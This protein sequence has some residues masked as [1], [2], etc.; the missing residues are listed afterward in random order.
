MHLY[1][2]ALDEGETSR[3]MMARARQIGLGHLTAAS[4]VT[5]AEIRALCPNRCQPVGP[6]PPPRPAPSRPPP[7][8]P[9]D[10]RS[11]APRRPST[12]GTRLPATA[13]ARPGARHPRPRAGRHRRR[14]GARRRTTGPR[15]R[16]AT[17]DRSAADA[18]LTE[19]TDAPGPTG[20]VAGTRSETPTNIV[21]V[22]QFCAGWP[23]VAAYHAQYSMMLAA[24][25]DLR[26]VDDWME[27][28]HPPRRH[29]RDRRPPGPRLRR[30]RPGRRGHER[31][32]LDLRR[33]LP[34]R[35]VGPRR[36]AP[37]HRRRR[38]ARR[39]PSRPPSPRPADPSHAVGRGHPI[40]EPVGRVIDP[41]GSAQSSS[42]SVRR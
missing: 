16:R 40:F 20:P 23:A 21:D 7:P 2:L 32:E 19:V 37:G 27:V 3:E 25:P 4:E 24:A 12:D 8:P 22:A 35:H 11:R 15:P 5:D 18:A 9:R 31:P 6:E 1:E 28:H 13:A 33:R 10:R 34:R 17:P 38:P 14:R 26:T 30:R 39:A 41:I 29:R 36:R 42:G